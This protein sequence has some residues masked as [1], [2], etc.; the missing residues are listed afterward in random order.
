M[1]HVLITVDT[2][3]SPALHRR[4]VGANPNFESSIRGRCPAGEFGVGWLMDELDACGHKGVFFVDPMPAL[5]YGPEV[6]SRIV[7]LILGRGHEVQL[8]IHTE[9]LEWAPASPVGDRRGTSIADFSADDQLVLL[10]TAA[11]LLQEAGAPPPIAFRAGNY[12]AD[13]RTLNALKALGIAWDSSFNG[14]F[15]QGTCRI[16][17][18]PE[19]RLP[20]RHQGMNELPV[21]SIVDRPGHLRPAQVC[22][23]SSSEMRAGLDHAAA[24]A[25]PV[26]T[27][28]TH[29]FEMMSRD[30]TRPNRLV[31]DRFRRLCR[32]I[33]EQPDLRTATFAE[34]DP[35]FARTNSRGA[36]AGPSLP[37]TAG[38]VLEQV[39]GT[40][41]YERRFRLP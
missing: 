34:L 1:T 10:D 5:V 28:V 29:S 37:R 39:L 2:E 33:H 23:M 36:G 41:I 17:L 31:M 35:E 27:I 13:D 24:H 9:W 30:R 8:H 19:T 7:G 32:T 18:P 14:A 20:V 25:E 15:S 16:G 4:G 22:A 40:W 26:F 21:S 12:G 6:V 38:R 3:L 11:Q